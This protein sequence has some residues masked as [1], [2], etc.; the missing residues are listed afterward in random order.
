MKTG[1]CK[2]KIENIVAIAPNLDPF[3][4][5][6]VSAFCVL[7][8]IALLGPAGCSQSP[9]PLPPLAAEQ[10]PAAMQK[11]FKDAR[12]EAKETIG[13]LASALEGKDYPAAYQEVQALCNL[14]DQTR[15]QRVLAAR[16]LLTITGLLHAA[17]AQGDHGAATALK[18]RQVSR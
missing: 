17:Q 14:Q 7:A 5:R 3:T 15:E 6:L 13:R 10:L 1:N 4:T 9:G 11:A 18:L 2:L 12:P 8:A 16:A